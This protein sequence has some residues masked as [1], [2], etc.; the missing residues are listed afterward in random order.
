MRNGMGS[1]NF[2]FCFLGAMAAWALVNS[3]LS[4]GGHGAKGEDSTRTPTSC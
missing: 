2:V 3:V 1:W 4:L